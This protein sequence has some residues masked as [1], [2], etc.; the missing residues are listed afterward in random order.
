MSAVIDP[1]LARTPGR[2]SPFSLLP[3][4]LWLLGVAAPCMAQKPTLPRPSQAQGA[5]EQAIQ[6]NPGLA[7]VIRHRLSQSG[8]T[9]DQI[10]ARLQVAGDPP[11]RIGRYL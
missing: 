9:R 6:Q 5:L 4:L 10:P 1:S 2:T 8:M 3:L 7:D 11:P